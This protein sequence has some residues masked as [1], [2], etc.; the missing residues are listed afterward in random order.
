MWD[1]CIGFIVDSISCLF[2]LCRIVVPEEVKGCCL[3]ALWTVLVLE[4]GKICCLFELSRVF[5][6]GKANDVVYLHY[7]EL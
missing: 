1:L 3:F 4:A 2:E 7:V 5:V 6:P